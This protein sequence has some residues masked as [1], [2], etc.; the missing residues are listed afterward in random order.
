MSRVGKLP[1]AIPEGVQVTLEPGRIAIKGK[2]GELTT[3]YTSDVT[4]EQTDGQIVVAPANDSKRSRSFWGTVRSL[5]GNMVQG[6]TEGFTIRLVVNGVGYRAQL[7][8]D[9]LSLALGYSHDIKYAVP[10]DIDIKVEKQTLLIIS[11]ADKQ[12][13]G[14]VASELMRLRPFEPYKGKGVYVEGKPGRRKE[15]KKK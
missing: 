6:V 2:N 14:Q 10:V 4:V 15:G 12:K 8:G 3:E 5:V 9:I 7:Q 13:V 1:V 11:G